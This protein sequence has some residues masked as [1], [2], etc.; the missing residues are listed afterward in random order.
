MDRYS[1]SGVAA[2]CTDWVKNPSKTQ[3]DNEQIAKLY[4]AGWDIISHG[5]DH[6]DFTKLTERE[7]ADQC[8]KSKK[9]LIE[10]GFNRG[11]DFIA[12]PFDAY[13]KETLQVIKQYYNS[14]CGTLYGYNAFP[15]IDPYNMHRMSLPVS[16][17]WDWEEIKEWIDET[18]RHKLL[19]II[20]IHDLEPK[21]FETLIDYLKEKNVD[22]MTF[23]QLAD[24][25]RFH[26]YRI[27]EIEIKHIQTHRN[28][29]SFLNQISYI[30]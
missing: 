16:E 21:T 5:L 14:T 9:W 30:K 19:T 10:H 7:I 15:L 1:Y 2:I 27:Y 13:D 28:E 6:T 8:Y 24:E 4:D 17:T 22:V 29:L 3:M 18:I 25:T 20:V 23:S 12:L 26:P 11:A